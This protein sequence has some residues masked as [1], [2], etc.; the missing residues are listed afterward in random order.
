MKHL[1]ILFLSALNIIIMTGCEKEEA[2]CKDNSVPGLVTNLQVENLPGAARIRYTLPSHENLLYV[3]AVYETKTGITREAKASVYVSNILLEGYGDTQ[4]RPVK[5]YAVTRC[6]VSSP[7]VEVK[8]NPQMPVIW[9]VFTSLIPKETF[10]GISVAYQ[11]PTRANIVIGIVVKDS[12][13]FWQHVDFHYSSQAA[14]NFSV[15]GFQQPQPPAPQKQ[16]TFGIY[17]KDRWDNIT[18]TLETIITPVYEELLDKS[19]FKDARSFNYPVPQL[20]PLPASGAPIVNAS[21]FSSSWVLTRLWDNN[22][23]NGFHTVERRDQP[24]WIP[25]DL[26]Q[27]GASKFVLSR[28]KIWQRVGTSYNFNHGNPH[29]WEI[30]G[31]NTPTNVNSWVL[32]DARTMIKPSGLPVGVNTNED[33]QVVTNGQEYEFPPGVPPVRYIAW[34]HIDSWSS[35]D[36]YLGFI[37]IM[38]MTIWG[39]KQ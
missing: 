4:E 33:I 17:V 10:S 27:T 19:R 2:E 5:L 14:N 36:G 24:I 16:W 38:E 12:L 20:P 28:Y 8:V 34:K 6:E 31:T 13:G 18:D 1:N 35:I 11:N 26:D 21:D 25:I 39:Q 37:H 32:L 29:K 9:N 30:W 15:R 7:A 3:K 22:L 23:S